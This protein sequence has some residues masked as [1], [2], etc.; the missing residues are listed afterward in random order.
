[1]NID[2]LIEDLRTFNG[3]SN[4]YAIAIQRNQ[5]IRQQ[6][7]SDNFGRVF[8]VMK[9]F[10]KDVSAVKRKYIRTYT[11]VPARGC[12]QYILTFAPPKEGYSDENERWLADNTRWIARMQLKTNANSVLIYFPNEIVITNRDNFKLGEHSFEILKNEKIEE[13]TANPENFICIDK[14]KARLNRV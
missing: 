14:V 11:P 7:E 8:Y 3:I 9:E 12:G 1:M 6:I 13:F 2:E 5:A 10:L 4:E